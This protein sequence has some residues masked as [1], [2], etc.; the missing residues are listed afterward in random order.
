MYDV[1]TEIQ[2]T[3]SQDS[4]AAIL[5]ISEDRP[6]AHDRFCGAAVPF[7]FDAHLMVGTDNAPELKKMLH[8][9][10]NDRRVKRVNLRNF[11]FRLMLMI[12]IVKLNLF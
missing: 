3:G 7:P 9:K 6:F 4:R 12:F 11:F 8:K 5:C 10:F 1:C 2:R